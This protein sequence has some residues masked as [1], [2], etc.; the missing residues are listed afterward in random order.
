MSFQPELIA[1]EHILQAFNDL[2]TQGGEL[3]KSTR[4]DVVHEGKRYPPKEVMRRAHFL[5]NQEHIWESS[6]GEPTNKYLKAFGFE[7]QEKNTQESPFFQLIRDYKELLKIEGLTDEIYKWELIQQFKGCPNL[8]AEDLSAELKRIKFQNLIYGPGIGVIQTL[9]TER[10]AGYRECLR[11]L[12]DDNT[13]LNQRIKAFAETAESL[14]RELNKNPNHLSHHDE[15]TAATLLTYHN[16]D[17]YTLYKDSFYRILCRVIGE[18]QRAPGE[19][20]AHY[21]DIVGDFIDGY[22]RPD[23]DLIAEVNRLKP[24]SAFEDTGLRIL[25]QDILYR[26]LEI[27]GRTFQT[28]MADVAEML[29]E[30]SGAANFAVM[31][32]VRGGK[33]R[34]EWMWGSDPS[35]LISTEMAHYEFEVLAKT[36]GSINICLHFEDKRNK[37]IFYQEIGKTLPNDLE[38]FSWEGAR[39]IR[40]KTPI[41]FYSEQTVTQI[42]DRLKFFDQAIGSQVR[43]IILNL[44]GEHLKQH[45][46]MSQPLNQILLGPPGTGKTYHTIN[47]ALSILDGDISGK[48]RQELKARFDQYLEEGRIVF[49]TFHQSLSYEDFVEG[50]KPEPQTDAGSIQ[51]DV[52]PGI[53]KLICNAARQQKDVKSQK[54]ESFSGVRFFKM[55]IGGLQNPHIH[56]W[57]IKN[58]CVGL[59]WGGDHHFEEFQRIKQ[60]KDY[61]E[62]FQSQFPDL[63]KESRY[64]ITAMFTFQNMNIGDIV[65]VSKGNHIIDAIGRIAGE[66]YWS[67]EN[68][69]EYYQ[70]RKVEWLAIDLNQS[71]ETFFKKKISQQSIYEFYDD[72]VKH[73]AFA[74]FFKAD[75][76]APKPY[77][78]I[79]DEINRGNVSRVFGELITLL[80]PD[81]RA[82]KSEALKVTLPYSRDEF[83]VPANL[84]VIGTMNTADRS[85]EALDTALRR[86]FSFTEIQPDPELLSTPLMLWQMIWYHKDVKSTDENYMAAEQEMLELFGGTEEIKTQFK[87][88][89]N[90][91]REKNVEQI[92]E[93]KS[94]YFAGFDLKKLLQVLNKR[95]EMLKDRDHQIGHAYLLNVRSVNDLMKVFRDNIIPLLQEYFF[96][97]Y[98]KLRLILGDGFISSSTHQVTFAVDEEDEVDTKEL[99]YVNT[100]AFSGIEAF[101]AAYAKMKL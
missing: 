100:D 35:G 44:N 80:E 55:S 25:A 58:N 74:D 16:P 21:L 53:F 89:H 10:T 79:I 101:R 40:L 31:S 51:Y 49:T 37:N 36:P 27:H 94:A 52:K 15:R 34:Y 5:A 71:P 11:K 42:I 39:S 50:I 8:E 72:D 59:G 9:A 33:G 99:F 96:G 47:K 81:K 22:V 30:E 6:G 76:Q 93:L 23:T 67:D 90:S 57:C 95:L 56:D 48:S 7:I 77:V 46:Q 97:D 45:I 18:T 65:V 78:L 91:W 75:K 64:N 84:Y 82:G 1:K 83:E 69:F 24:P 86:R 61:R 17:R 2:D 73:E 38:W 26:M 19:K 20:Y 60:W 62:K 14:H 32:Q 87:T 12:F 98:R 28:L 29:T 13:D 66:Y 68:D 43:Q 3:K 70:F 88:I 4:Y 85:V 63:V 92:D 41:S 54:E